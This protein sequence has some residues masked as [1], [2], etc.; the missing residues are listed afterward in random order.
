MTISRA[1]AI[2]RNVWLREQDETW[3]T[4]RRIVA[5]V[6]AWQPPPRGSRGHRRDD[7]A[8]FLLPRAYTASSTMLPASSCLPTARH[9]R[10]RLTASSPLHLLT[11]LIIPLRLAHCACCGM[12]TL[13]R[14]S[15]TIPY[16][17]SSAICLPLL[18]SY[19]MRTT[20]VSSPP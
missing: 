4:W 15:S 11:S 18:F 12:A 13:S 8:P 10:H 20:R 7:G 17:L 14:A 1:L 3:A 2:A 16:T 6:G 19:T 5:N 9:S